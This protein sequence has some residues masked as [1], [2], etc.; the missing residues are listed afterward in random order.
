MNKQLNLDRTYDCFPN[1][2][3]PKEQTIKFRQNLRWRPNV[4]K[5]NE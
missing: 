1:D 2:E 5:P 3:K 4:E